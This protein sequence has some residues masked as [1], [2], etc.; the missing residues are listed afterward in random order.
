M[1]GKPKS[2]RILSIASYHSF[3]DRSLDQFPLIS[4]KSTS[5]LLSGTP[6][7]PGQIP[8]LE[9]S[10]TS[11]PISGANGGTEEPIPTPPVV[12]PQPAQATSAP[13]PTQQRSTYIPP[14]RSQSPTLCKFGLKCTTPSCRYSHPSPVAT[15]ESGII[16]S[17]Q[18]RA[19]EGSQG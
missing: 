14:K 16:S 2:V 1:T 5:A 10:S 6:P 8:G 3:I 18:W 17:E 4:K 12:A 9:R 7:I 19:R 13:A 15:P 11:L